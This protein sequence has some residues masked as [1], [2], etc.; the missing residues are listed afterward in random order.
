MPRPGARRTTRDATTARASTPTTLARTLPDYL[1]R[2]GGDGPSLRNCEEAVLQLIQLLASEPWP[3]STNS[4]RVAQDLLQDAEGTCSATMDATPGPHRSHHHGIL[5]ARLGLQRWPPLD[6]QRRQRLEV[7]TRRQTSARCSGQP[8]PT[9]TTEGAWNSTEQTRRISDGA[10]NGSG[11]AASTASTGGFSQ[12]HAQAHGREHDSRPPS[13]TGAKSASAA[14][15]TP[16]TIAS[17][18]SAA[19]AVTAPP[20]KTGGSPER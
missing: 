7:P 10:Y 9:T 15:S 16:T 19:A 1:S 14:R 5:G 11:T 17:G 6:R 12:Q 18:T 2:L 4:T 20:G 13:A 8:R 3:K